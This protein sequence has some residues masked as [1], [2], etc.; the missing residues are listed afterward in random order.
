MT[1]QELTSTPQA[2]NNPTAAEVPAISLIQ[3]P[4][5][6]TMTDED[7]EEEE[8]PGQGG[9]F[10]EL[11]LVL[12]FGDSLDRV[13]V[14]RGDQKLPSSALVT[15]NSVTTVP[16]LRPRRNE[17]CFANIVCLCRSMHLWHPAFIGF[18]VIAFN[19]LVTY[20]FDFWIAIAKDAVGPNRIT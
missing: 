1:A 11:G 10:Q 20:G 17:V 13:A 7:E 3:A 2:P 9:A 8:V 18:L 6:C 19:R 15:R 14:S 4:C 12:Y 5:T 16:F